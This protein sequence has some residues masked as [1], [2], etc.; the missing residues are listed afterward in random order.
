VDG[1]F[2]RLRLKNFD[3][4]S[5]VKRGCFS[6]VFRAYD[7]TTSQDVAL[8][9]YSI[10]SAYYNDKYRRAAFQREHEI[11]QA[12]TGGVRCL[13]VISPYSEFQF[14]LPVASGARV[15]IPCPY[16]AIEWID[17]DI[18]EY[19]LAQQNF[20]AATKLELFNEIVLAVEAL[21]R[22]GVC[23]RDLKPDNLR[24]R[25]TGAG[26]AIVAIDLGTAAK[27]TST[28]L[29]AQYGH[30]AGAPAYAAP[31]ARCGLAGVRSIAPQDDVYALG[32]LLYELFNPGLFVREVLARNPRI[33][34]ILIAISAMVPGAVS[35]EG[36][37]KAWT[38]GLN[39]FAH[40]IVP[41]KI[42]GAGSSLP[43]GIARLMNELLERMTHVDFRRRPIDLVSIRQR[44][45]AA[46]RLLRNQTEYERRLSLARERRRRRA[47]RAREKTERLAR[48]LAR[49]VANA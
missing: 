19:F 45:W 14:S 47:E 28:P 12:L 21:H 3:A 40:G 44:I 7:R 30:P 31:E 48:G 46:I 6:L 17:A 34:P 23:H 37:V 8:K 10:D 42:D 27:S 16:F 38:E 32:C 39:R 13:Q 4:L 41:V 49:R 33:Q 35:D 20:D 29:L 9:F 18:D 2:E 1:R 11:L 26:R 24:L 22:R 25:G 5:D 43:R 15:T 36:R